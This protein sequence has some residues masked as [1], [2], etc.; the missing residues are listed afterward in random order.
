M[1]R[2]AHC[3]HSDPCCE[4]CAKNRAYAASWRA[5][6]PEK[7]KK[8]RASPKC[9]EY[10]KRWRSKN[11][12]RSSAAQERFRRKPENREAARIAAS[13]WRSSNRDR[14]RASE[15][16]WKSRNKQKVRAMSVKH[17]NKRKALKRGLFVDEVD[18][19]EIARLQCGICY[20][21]STPMGSDVTLDHLVPLTKMGPH[22]ESNS[23]ACHKRCNSAKGDRSILQF[24]LRRR[25]V[26]VGV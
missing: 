12:E 22:S 25:S 14:A 17:V 5:R 11:P 6:N 20:L 21:C 7:V 16:A 24:L 19:R 3:K 2:K 23:A 13:R 15:M 8:Y 1:N 18:V 10:T 9:W 26:E 4:A